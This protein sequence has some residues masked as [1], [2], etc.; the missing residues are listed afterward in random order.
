MSKINYGRVIL[1]GV[2]GGIVAGFLDWFLNGVLMRQHWDDAMK[3]LNR[4]SAFSG[5]FLFCLFLVYSIGGILIVWVYAAI[6][7]RFG[8]GVRTAVYAGLVAWAFASLLPG[9]MDAVEGLYSPRLM[10][11]AIVAGILELVTG[12]IIGAALYKEE[13]TAAYPAAAPQATH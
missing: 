13:A 10:L 8:G 7:P 2:V 12:A 4:P 1:G 3:S 9:T 6:R 5:A 11:Y